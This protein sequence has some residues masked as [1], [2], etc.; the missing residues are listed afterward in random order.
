MNDIVINDSVIEFSNNVKILGITIANHHHRKKLNFTTHINNT[1]NKIIKIKNILFHLVA[2]TWGINDKKRLVLY[3]SLIRPSLT[4]GCQ[5]W[6]SHLN[7]NNIQKL[8]KLQYNILI[9]L[10]K[11]YKYTSNSCIEVLSQCPKL[12]EYLDS[13]L[14]IWRFKQNNIISDAIL[15]NYRYIQYTYTYFNNNIHI[16]INNNI[17]INYIFTIIIQISHEH[18][19]YGS[20]YIQSSNT[21]LYTK[22]YKFLDKTHNKIIE[23]YTT[24]KALKLLVRQHEYNNGNILTLTN[25]NTFLKDIKYPNN[26]DTYQLKLHNILINN[27][28][29]LYNKTN[30]NIITEEITPITNKTNKNFLNNTSL[31]TFKLEEH[32]KHLQNSYNQTN[33]NFKEYITTPILPKFFF[34]NFYSNQIITNNGN[35]NS[36]LQKINLKDTPLCTCSNTTQTGTHLLYDCQILK[37]H[38]NTP[39]EYILHNKKNFKN[40]IKQTQTTYYT[41]KQL[42]DN[43]L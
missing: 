16:N 34:N 5:I 26:I 38:H 41:K 35:F 14:L 18:N 8:N 24:Y 9:K 43:T 3:K 11:C 6:Y 33:T 15:N 27:N 22:K 28:I 42:I 23:S 13:E 29:H 17:S 25:S 32:K 31:K 30:R 39:K 10:T 12:S 40:F 7:K 1:L 36:Y 2:N 19:T 21:T 20:F 4:Y 37:I